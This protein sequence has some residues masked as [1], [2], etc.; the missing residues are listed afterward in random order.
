MDSYPCQRDL[1]PTELLHYAQDYF[2]DG[3][4]GAA[5]FYSTFVLGIPEYDGEA[6]CL[7]SNATIL[8]REAGQALDDDLVKR[9]KDSGLRVTKKNRTLLLEEWSPHWDNYM[10]LLRKFGADY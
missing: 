5:L 9:L 1:T 7:V 10:C 3:D 4:I 6:I 2:E 8:Q